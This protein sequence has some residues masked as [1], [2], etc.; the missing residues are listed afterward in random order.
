MIMEGF[1][2]GSADDRGRDDD[3]GLCEE[4]STGSGGKVIIGS[5]VWVDD[6][7]FAIVVVVGKSV[8]PWVDVV[9]VAAAIGVGDPSSESSPSSSSSSSESA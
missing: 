3:D 2:D 7:N 4:D 5:K 6:E 9:V 1:V 8:G